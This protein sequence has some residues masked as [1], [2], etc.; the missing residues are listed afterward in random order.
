MNRV[1]R[2]QPRR[3]PR[4]CARRSSR[5]RPP[6][7]RRS[8]RRARTAAR[9]RRAAAR[10]L[11]HRRI[12]GV[13][14]RPVAGVLVLEDPRLRRR[15]RL[16]ARMPIEVIGREVQHHRDPRMER[17]DLLELKAARLDDVQRV[18][19]RAADLRAQRRADVAADRH[20]ESGRFE[21][22]PGQRR[23]RR[24][25]LR[26]GDRDHAAR[27]A[28]ATR[29]RLRRSPARRRARAPRPPAA[30]AARPG[31]ARRDPRP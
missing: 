11:Q 4:R 26:A 22:P 16:D 6:C 17:V 5:P 15:V 27:A 19:R 21:H 13:D 20:L 28:S 10:Q 3:L 18:G 14:H 7:L 29:A 23:R 12:V 2:H 9:R 30:R 1:E 8:C 31:S 25:P 24:L